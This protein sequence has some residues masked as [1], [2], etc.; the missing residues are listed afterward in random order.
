MS[1]WFRSALPLLLL[2]HLSKGPQHGYILMEALRAEG[3]DVKGATVYPHLNR[4]QE[5]GS[6]ESEWHTP[7]NGPARKVMTI[8]PAGSAR[9]VVLQRQWGRFRDQI[10]A[11]LGGAKQGDDER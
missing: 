8:T 11:A 4:L 5:D 3:F 9:L 6:I 2:T 1:E 7:E 10:D